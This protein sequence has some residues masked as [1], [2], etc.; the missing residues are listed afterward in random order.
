MLK[1]FCFGFERNRNPFE[2]LNETF[3]NSWDFIFFCTFRPFYII[4]QLYSDFFKR[5]YDLF[6][7]IKWSKKNTNHYLKIL[8]E[9]K[10]INESEADDNVQN[11]FWLER[12][13]W[14]KSCD[15]LLEQSN[16]LCVVRCKQQDFDLNMLNR[17]VIIVEYCLHFKVRRSN[18][19]W[20]KTCCMSIDSLWWVRN[21]PANDVR[22]ATV[23]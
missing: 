20:L 23:V 17:F 4:V 19:H 8:I 5:T 14:N 10:I 18:D 2:K 6:I 1:A 9:A 22:E 15:G 11:L 7:A 16:M 12:M 13:M 3:W 21:N